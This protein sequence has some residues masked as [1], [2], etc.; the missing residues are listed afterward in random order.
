MLKWFYEEDVIVGVSKNW[1]DKLKMVTDDLADG[2]AVLE[3][4]QPF[5]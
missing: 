1:L 4:T 5:E 2:L 3:P